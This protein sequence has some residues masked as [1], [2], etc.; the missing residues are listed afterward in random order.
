MENKMKN[1]YLVCVLASCIMFSGCAALV[2]APGYMSAKTAK[3][4]PA[5]KIIKVSAS[6]NETFNVVARVLTGNVRTVTTSDREA[7]IIQGTINQNAVKVK[8][9]ENATKGSDVNIT[10]SYVKDLLY[11]TSKLDD[12]LNTIVNDINEA[13]PTVS[14][15]VSNGSSSA[16]QSVDKSTPITMTVQQAQERLNALGYAVGQPDGLM[17]KKT[18]EQLKAFQLS[19]GVLQTGKLDEKTIRELSI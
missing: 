14:H 13:I 10:V 18:R 9:T 5:N 2:E 19:R 6:K 12:D 11:G 17:G 1:I 7:G 4:H 8:I 15:S 3:E 16:S